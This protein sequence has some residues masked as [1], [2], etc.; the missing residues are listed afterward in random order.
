MDIFS[1]RVRLIHKYPCLRWF[2]F[3]LTLILIFF[4]HEKLSYAQT[5]SHEIYLPI[6][7]KD[8]NSAQYWSNPAA[9]TL[10][11][12]PHN[13]PLAVLD[14]SGRL[15][16]IWDTLYSPRFL[17]HAY[18][19]DQGWSAPMPIAQTLG[20]SYTM[21]VPVVDQRGDIHLLWR[22]YL[23][24]GVENPHRLLYA[25]FNGS[26]WSIEEEIVRDNG[27]KQ[28]MVHLDREDG[29]HV[30]YVETTFASRV[31][32][33][34]RTNSG[35][36]DPIEIKRPSFSVSWIWADMAGGVHFFGD[37][38]QE[39]VHHSYWLNGETVI[40]D[41]VS[42][43]KV[44]G[45]NTQLDGQN[46]LHLFWTGQTPVPGG[47]VNSLFYQCLDKDLIMG[48][49][50]ILSGQKA[51][52]GEIPKASDNVSGFALAW[53]ELSSGVIQVA[54]GNGCT[55]P[56]I[57]PVPYQNGINWSV[58]ALAISSNPEKVCTLAREAYSQKYTAICG[59][60]P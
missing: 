47:Q 18:L 7:A 5:S 56:R 6:L 24:S 42:S 2:V 14:Q 11:P 44:S 3:I 36:T 22:N 39:N 54:V 9:I 49:E 60:L 12:T 33:R 53:K 37:D 45:R 58:K 15:H 25:N 41:R 8:F 34:V 32:H 21:Y 38:Y 55:Q 1:A 13:T 30:T 27:Q 28:G 16:L 23:S 50:S 20:T 17:Y 46:N 52:T 35:W 19:S 29:I 4:S 57:T 48:P 43:G 10:A 51:I 26:Q 40:S 31:F 59:S